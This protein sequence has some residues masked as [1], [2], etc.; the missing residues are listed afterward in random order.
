MFCYCL[1][2]SIFWVAQVCL[3]VFCAEPSEFCSNILIELQF[4][5]RYWLV[6]EHIDVCSIGQE[7]Q[8]C[9]SEADEK[10]RT[11]YTLL[12][13]L[14]LMNVCCAGRLQRKVL[15]PGLTNKSSLCGSRSFVYAFLTA[16]LHLQAQVS[17]Q[18]REFNQQEHNKSKILH[19]NNK[20]QC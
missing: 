5:G 6:W 13:V 10:S 11:W 7:D 12:A 17:H 1:G 3:S 16:I 20:L 19:V 9:N 15:P 18:M 8:S 2:V 14:L 4:I